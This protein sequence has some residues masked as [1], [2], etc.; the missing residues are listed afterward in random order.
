MAQ[1]ID[2][3][4]AAAKSA[5]SKANRDFPNANAPKSPAAPAPKAAPAPSYETHSGS[6]RDQNHQVAQEEAKKMGMSSVPILHKGGPVLKDGVYRLKAGE[7][8]LASGEADKARKHALLASGIK[9]LANFGK[10]AGEPTK[11][12]PTEK[13]SVSGIVIRAEKNQSNKIASPAKK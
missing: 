13:K 9:S 5:L 3:K 1:D 8:V 11:K 10:S 6:V 2:S 4:V 12:K 7:H